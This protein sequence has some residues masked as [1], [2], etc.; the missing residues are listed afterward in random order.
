MED[1]SCC[2]IHSQ[3]R[4][5]RQR[6]RLW[7]RFRLHWRNQYD[8]TALD[9]SILRRAERLL[10]RHPL[11]AYD[12]VQIATAIQVV[13]AGSTAGSDVLF[14]TADAGQRQAAVAEGLGVEFIS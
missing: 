6:E 13:R 8:V 3:T 1:R 5:E 4:S 7:Q 9:E 2:L 14:C 11:R 10:F 12:A